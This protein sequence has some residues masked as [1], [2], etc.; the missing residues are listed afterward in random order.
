VLYHQRE[1]SGKP[2]S[3]NRLRT[4]GNWTDQAA[5]FHRGVLLQALTAPFAD[6]YE[7]EQ[8]IIKAYEALAYRPLSRCLNGGHTE[9]FLPFTDIDLAKWLPEGT[10]HRR[11]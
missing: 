3:V 11:S 2:P 8:E 4:E 1:P 6:C 9:C 10:V 7:A 5:P